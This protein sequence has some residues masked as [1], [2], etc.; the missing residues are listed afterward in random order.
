MEK[1]TREQVEAIMK[2][3]HDRGVRADLSGADL[4]YAKLTGA[5]LSSANLTDLIRD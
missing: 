5:N 3:A 4:G 1:M 2:D